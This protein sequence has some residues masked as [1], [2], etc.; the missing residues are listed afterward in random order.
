MIIAIIQAR[1][2]S[3]RLPGKVLMDVDGKPM[4]KFMY[5][6]VKKSKLIDKI[7]VAT[8]SNKIDDSIAELCKKEKIIC[9]RGSED[10]TLD[11]YYKAALPYNPNIVVRLTGDCPL[12]DPVLVDKTINLFVK[13]NVDYASNTVPPDIK[14]FPDGSDVEVFSFRNLKKSWEKST[15]IKE[16]EHVTFYFWKS[17]NNFSTAL[18]DNK[19]NWGKYRI[20]I[21]YKEDMTLLNEI[22]KR[23]KRQNKFGHINEVVEILE[24]EPNLVEINSMYTYGLNW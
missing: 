21:D 1:M 6:R 18:L 24:N 10:D 11:R 14:K 22:I 7:I 20:T 23:L 17:G 4:I 13:K 15:C 16:R 8:T 12:C 3:S 9:F 2:G 19:F 5:D